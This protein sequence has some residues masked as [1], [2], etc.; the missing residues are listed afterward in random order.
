LGAPAWVDR[1]P[2]VV[3]AR[4]GAPLVVAASRRNPD[5]THTLSVLGVHD[6]PPDADRAWA[7]RVTVEATRALE[8]F[9]R[10][11]PEDW[12]WLHRRWAAPA[13]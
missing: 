5:G 6:P 8:R 1:A 2:A 4:A 7:A 11:N 9:I 10:D 12:L 13:A 3:A